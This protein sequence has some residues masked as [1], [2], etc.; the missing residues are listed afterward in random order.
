MTI[1]GHSERSYT[2]GTPPA[3]LLEGS[4]QQG[5]ITNGGENKQSKKE[6]TEKK[7]ETSDKTWVSERTVGDFL[8]TF[9]FPTP[10]D[11][12]KCKASMKNGILSI[13]VPK[14][15]EKKQSRR[16]AIEG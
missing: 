14:V 7:E 2:S 3:G 16:I 1:R 9:N 15:E 5:K 6:G 13:N 4:R 12:D 11:Q 10:V 8:R